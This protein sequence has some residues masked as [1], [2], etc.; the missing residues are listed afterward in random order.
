M[1]PIT[2]AIGEVT[3]T[4][5]TM[6]GSI[7][8]GII[9]KIAASIFMLSFALKTMSGIEPD[10]L[11]SAALGMGVA[12]S[13]IVAS[14]AIIAKFNSATSVAKLIGI[15]IALTILSLGFIGM[16]KAMKTLGGLDLS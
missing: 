16:A 15:S 8:A 13:A 3:N 14:F 6:Q 4:L 5:K 10:R 1:E 2:G 7:K 11:Q 9:V 12:L